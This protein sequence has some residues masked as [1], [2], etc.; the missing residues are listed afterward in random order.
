MEAD[1]LELMEGERKFT[2]YYESQLNNCLQDCPWAV[3]DFL[4]ALY[5][6]DRETRR[7]MLNG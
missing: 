3:A 6:E 4:S 7:R 1:Y 5:R 2:A